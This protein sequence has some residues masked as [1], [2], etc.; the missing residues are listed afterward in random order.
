MDL[1]YRPAT[2]ALGFK[3][4]LYICEMVGSMKEKLK[5]NKKIFM[6]MTT[7]RFYFRI[8]HILTFT[9]LWTPNFQWS[10][11]VLVRFTW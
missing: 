11:F 10:L 8:S 7:T 1:W 5:I 3:Y 4:H 6:N 2:D 9:S